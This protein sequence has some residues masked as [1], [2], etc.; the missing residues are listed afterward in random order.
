MTQST[1]SLQRLPTVIARVGLS[2]SSI[3]ARIKEGTFPAPVVLGEGRAVAWD[4]RAID[5]WIDDRV[6][7]AA[8]HEVGQ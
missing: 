1:F 8:K 2:R 6:A 3:Y 7:A 5:K 4:S